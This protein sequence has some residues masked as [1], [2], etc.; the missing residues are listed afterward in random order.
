MSIQTFGSV[1]TC[2]YARMCVV[3]VRMGLS[4]KK[5]G[6]GYTLFSGKGLSI[7]RDSV[8]GISQKRG[9]QRLLNA[10]P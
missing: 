10:D 8:L 2:Y 7:L 3:N 4:F 1:K 5:G 9:T 6:E